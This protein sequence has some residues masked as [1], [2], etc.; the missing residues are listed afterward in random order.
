[1]NKKI[2]HTV[3][4]EVAARL[5]E[6]T[7][8]CE[9]NKS[10]SYGALN[11]SANR[12]AHLLSSRGLGRESIA[13]VMMP[14]SI[15][16]VTA[17][18]AIFKAGGIYLPVDPA[19]PRKRLAG[20]FAHSVPEILITS[21]DVKE[22]VLETL[23]A[24]EMRLPAVLVLGQENKLSLY[25]QHNGAW[26][27]VQLDETVLSAAN[28]KL[29]NEPDDGNYIFYTSGSTGEA[30]AFLG[31]HK[32]LSHFIH[33][34]G[35]TLS[36]D[37]SYRIS[38]LSQ[39][40]FDAS[41]RDI[42]LP[43]TYGATLYI[44]AAA[45]KTNMVQLV[46][47]IANTGINLVHCVPSLFRLITK[48]LGQ[49]SAGN[50]FPD[51]KYVLMAGEPLY[52]KDIQRWRE[53]AGAHTTI[54]NLYGTSETTMAKTFY[55]IGDTGNDPSQMIPAGQPIDNAA[56][57][58]LNDGIP[59]TAGET[60]EVYIRTPFMTK[61]YYRNEALNKEVFVQNPLVDFK[62]LLHRTGDL[63][64]F[65]PDGNLEV[66]GRTDDQVKVNGVR[67]GLNEITQAVVRIPGVQDAVVTVQQRSTMENELLCYFIA[68]QLQVEELRQGLQEELNPSLVPSFF[69]KMDRFPLTVNGKVDKKALPKP[70]SAVVDEAMY[71][72]PEGPMEKELEAMWKELLGI[73]RIGRNVPFFKIGGTSLK[74]IQLI[75][76]IYKQYNVLVK[77][78]DIFSNASI[79]QLTTLIAGRRKGTD[80][81]LP[82]KPQPY[83][84]VTHAQKRLWIMDQFQAEK[85]AYNIPG[86]FFLQGELHIP[87]LENAFRQT[88]TRHES[89]RT[90]FAMVDGA[91]MSKINEPADSL[92][93]LEIVDCRGKQ[94]TDPAVKAI[95]LEKLTAPFDLELGPLLRACLLQVADNSHVLLVTMH[96]IIS[97]GWS[98]Q[99]MVKELLDFYKGHVAGKENVLPPLPV[100]YKDYTA[101]LEQRLSAEAMQAHRRYWLGR[102]EG[103]LP[104]LQLPTDFPRPAVKS[105]RG[106][107]ASF[108]MDA[109]LATMI[110]EAARSN[111]VSVYM[112][113]LAVLNLLLHHYSGQH[114]LVVGSPIAGR[115]HKDLGNQ[116][117]LYVNLLAIRTQL[118][119]EAPFSELLKKVK[120]ALLG[121]YEHQL[122]P[123]DLLV[124]ELHLEHDERRSPLTDVWIQHSDHSWIQ[125]LYSE[126]TGQLR[127]QPYDAGYNLSKVDLTFKFTESVD[128]IELVIEYN[129]DLFEAATIN[130]M[131]NDLIRLAA[132]AAR[133][134]ERPVKEIVRALQPAA[135]ANMMASLI[136]ESISNE[137]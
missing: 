132:I 45:T 24:L 4:E 70:E 42:F 128:S 106:A 22:A 121:A 52:V 118:Q 1:M 112:T 114:D 25:K 35:K 80:D 17:L 74:A 104:V 126:E 137:Y 40:T 87:S 38:Q 125:Q 28:P 26:T 16:L 107:T 33:W 91:V 43:L 18:L 63:G 93:T 60:G 136:S 12:I 82:V 89:L 3:F 49:G 54:I 95:A 27:A 37:E 11:A 72:A 7:A 113:L 131:G 10:I 58:V 39:F 120:T 9:E 135:A 44:P 122:Y 34:E 69:I 103:E 15:H 30:K 47:W 61:G 123:F 90:I 108:E 134:A 50:P 32:S 56:V 23:S 98:I 6:E 119:L 75:S 19:F 57:L 55:R 2:I 46:D 65:L 78:N 129:T 66:L 31:C 53:L 84:P 88:I 133:E 77:V 14:G 102:F 110:R 124:K 21:I 13:A 64:R 117:G 97:D 100:Q 105:T 83:Y 8:I 86:A 101:W 76:K 29:I 48:E 127:I 20:M 67:A 71:E 116:V 99:V 111:D 73:G 41:L 115:V 59:C 85:T 94:A 5:P 109:A 96:H 79:A 68:P 92:F 62:D 51:L 36:I 81:I 130:R